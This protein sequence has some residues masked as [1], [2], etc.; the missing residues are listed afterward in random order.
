MLIFRGR[1]KA[2][3]PGHPPVSQRERP[4]VVIPSR[5]FDFL[6]GLGENAKVHEAL[7]LD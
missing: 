4:L 6:F 3:D 1:P 5:R 7:S 2:A